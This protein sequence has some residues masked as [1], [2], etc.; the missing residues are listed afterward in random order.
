MRK[1]NVLA[2][3]LVLLFLPVVAATSLAVPANAEPG[4]P[5]RWLAVAADGT[6]SIADAGP[7][8][9]PLALTSYISNETANGI[10]VSR[11]DVAGNYQAILAGHRRTD[12]APLNWS[13]AM[14]FYVGPGYCVDAWFYWNGAWRFGVSAPGAREYLVDQTIEGQSVARWALRNTRPLP[15]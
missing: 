6:A 7:A 12:D 10:G 9:A 15:C 2:R 8:V 14:S 5:A 3:R 13:R 4:A 1:I 11:D